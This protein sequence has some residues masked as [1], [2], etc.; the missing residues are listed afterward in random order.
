[1]IAILRIFP[2]RSNDACCVVQYVIVLTVIII[3]QLILVIL[4]FSKAVS[5]AGLIL[6]T[7][8]YT[9]ILNPWK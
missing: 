7:Q 3:V 5:T 1:M 6:F 2:E 8:A 9:V 4:F